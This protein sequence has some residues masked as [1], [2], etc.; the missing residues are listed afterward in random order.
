MDQK[1]IQQFDGLLEKYTELMVGESDSNILAKVQMWALY[2]HI[3]KSMPPLVKHWNESYPE[4]KE[5]MKEVIT[6]IKRLN[7]EHRATNAKK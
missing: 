1:F 4:A 2:T 5:Q 3:A 6:E 7:E